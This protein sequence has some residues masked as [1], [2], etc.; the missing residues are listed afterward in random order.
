MNIMIRI[1]SCNNDCISSSH[2]VANFAS[3]ETRGWSATKKSLKIQ[4]T[5]SQ[6][7]FGKTT[8]IVEEKNI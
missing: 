5:F 6:D 4:P 8:P 3:K 7:K 2:L 1:P